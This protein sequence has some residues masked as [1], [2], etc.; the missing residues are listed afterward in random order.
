MLEDL[1]KD[2]L[3]PESTKENAHYK[4]IWGYPA[5]NKMKQEDVSLYTDNFVTISQDKLDGKF[6]LTIEDNYNLTNKEFLDK[7]DKA[8]STL[9]LQLKKSTTLFN[10]WNKDRDISIDYNYHNIYGVASSFIAAN[11]ILNIIY[12]KYKYEK[13]LSELN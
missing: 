8:T 6:Y 10:G 11:Y 2:I 3:L 13:S 5:S 12:Y 9:K 4:F 1:I 7:L